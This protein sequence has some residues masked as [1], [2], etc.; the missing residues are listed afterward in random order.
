MKRNKRIWGLRTLG[1]REEIV[2]I[3][4][5]HK[6]AKKSGNKGGRKIKGQSRRHGDI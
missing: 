2:N 6:M 1:P 4:A 3:K 5:I